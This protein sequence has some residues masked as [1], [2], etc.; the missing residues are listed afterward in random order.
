MGKQGVITP[1]GLVPAVYEQHQHLYVQQLEGR[2]GRLY[3]QQQQ[4]DCGPGRLYHLPAMYA[5]SS[6]D[7]NNDGSYADQSYGHNS[8]NIPGEEKGFLKIKFGLCANSKLFFF[9]LCLILM[10]PL[11]LT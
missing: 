8:E 9:L 1:A 2:P 10:F 11:L 4:Q 5:P 6:V 3:E 7:S